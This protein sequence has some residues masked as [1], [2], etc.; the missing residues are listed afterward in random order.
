MSRKKQGKTPDKEQ[1]SSDTPK[2]QA[3]Q[4]AGIP[5]LSAV[6]NVIAI[7]SGKGGVGKSSVAANLAVALKHS[8]YSVGLLDADI[9]G[10]SQPGMFGAG[11]DRPDIIEGRIK[12]LKKHGISFIS[13]GL[14][15]SDDGPVVWRAPMAIKIIHQ[16]LGNVLWDR[17]DYLLID[18]PPG[19]GD[20]QLTLAQQASLT[21]AVIVT[22]PQEVA[23]GVAK[24]GLKMFEQVNV[25]ILGIIENMSG[26]T[27][28]HCGNETAIFGAG[29]G[30]LM[31]GECKVPLL[32]SIPLDPE[33]MM[34]GENGIPVLVKS[35]DSPASKAYLDLVGKLK[36]RIDLGDRPGKVPE[37]RQIELLSGNQL[38]VIW[39][40][41]HEGLHT[42][43]YLRINC[44]CASCQDENTGRRTLDPDNVPLDIKFT[45]VGRVG[46]YAIQ[47]SFSDGHNTGIYAFQILRELCE[48]A[49]CM[50]AKKKDGSFPV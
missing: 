23:L 40:D 45:G 28:K 21:G 36:E 11:N 44:K 5:G 17:L 16:F 14:L 34:S 3:D 47:P 2:H 31:A 38:R 39:P 6:K 33:I 8:G 37:P 7:A 27:C 12:P 41:N 20:V 19:T 29:G 46:R 24:K 18:L 15:L 13:M 25:P 32:S 42:A 26:F 1:K 9:Y 35:P 30:K 43:Y 4:Q 48:C 10:P 22:T 49:D 50:K